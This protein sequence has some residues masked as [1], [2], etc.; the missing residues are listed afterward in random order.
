M[1]TS[2]KSKSSSSED[3]QSKTKDIGPR[4]RERANQDDTEELWDEDTSE[5]KF[6]D[7]QYLIASPV[8]L[9]YS[10]SEKL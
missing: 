4:S 7:E 8:V 5:R 1:Q 3:S 10:L 6:T 9:G 2:A